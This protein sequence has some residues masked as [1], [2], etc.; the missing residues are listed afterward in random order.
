[1]TNYLIIGEGGMISS[2]F[3]NYLKS[4]CISDKNVFTISTRI[5]IKSFNE[6]LSFML[7][8]NDITHI[9]Y[10]SSYPKFGLLDH[11]SVLLID[12]TLTYFSVVIDITKKIN[13]NISIILFSSASFDCYDSKL[14]SAYL[15]AK[16]CAE[17]ILV[18]SGLKNYKILKLFNIYGEGGG[19]VVDSLKSKFQSKLIENVEVYGSPEVMRNFLHVNRLIEFILNDLR[20][21]SDRLMYI[22][23]PIE[24]SI[25]DLVSL[26]NNKYK[27]SYNY[28]TDDLPKLKNLTLSIIPKTSKVIFIGQKNDLKNY[29]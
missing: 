3:I 21:I 8:R 23:G 1:M 10:L 13:S 19:L 29:I 15:S 9:L 11:E 18:G 20:N 4:N 14:P 24:L 26:F 6:I 27:K 12:K 17:I 28:I 22:S 16:R 2:G 25:G 7:T 5:E